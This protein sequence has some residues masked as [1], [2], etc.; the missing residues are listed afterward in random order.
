[1]NTFITK[2]KY[3]QKNIMLLRINV[4]DSLSIIEQKQLPRNF[5]SQL[6]YKK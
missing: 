1:M 4:K 6:P 5:S 2:E 3:Q